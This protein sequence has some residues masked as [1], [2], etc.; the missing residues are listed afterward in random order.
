[1]STSAVFDVSGKTA[2]VTGA[3]SG[4]GA[5]FVHVLRDAGANVIAAARRI[6]RL[7][8]LAQGSEQVLPVQCDVTNPAQCEALIA[9][10]IEAFGTI[11]ILVNNAGASGS[12]PAEHEPVEHFS[13]VV[14]VNLTAVFRLSQLAAGHM[15]PR[16][17]GVIINVASMFGLVASG[18]IPQASYAA[19]KGAV[20]N[21]TRELAVQWADRGVRVNAI[22][23]GWF[24]TEMTHGLFSS[25]RGQGWLRRHTP[26]R[27]SGR[28]DELD[29]VLLFLASDAST[30]VTGQC[31]AVDGGWVAV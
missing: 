20:V 17:E 10:A 13:R 25:D 28:P 12:Q 23:P 26:M 16:G 24:P 30:F 19:S 22:A 8:E 4:L 27:R 21:L 7:D 6:E 31:I 5:R 29:G 15:L 2:V 11:D 9:G 3:S 14:D 1:M 18:R